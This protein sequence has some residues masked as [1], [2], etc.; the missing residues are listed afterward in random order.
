LKAAIREL[1]SGA[2]DDMLFYRPVSRQREQ[3][4]RR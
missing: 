3:L 2:R 1:T 4:P